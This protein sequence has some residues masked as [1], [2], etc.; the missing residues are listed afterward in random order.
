MFGSG[1]VTHTLILTL[2]E[3]Y[4]NFDTITRWLEPV[5]IPVAVLIRVGVNAG[6]RQNKNK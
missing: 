6:T 5:V 2:L 4:K 3:V 1:I